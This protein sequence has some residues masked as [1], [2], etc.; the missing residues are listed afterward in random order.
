MRKFSF[1]RLHLILCGL[2]CAM[3]LT[4]CGFQ[5][6]GV[7]NL[8]FENLYI[9]GS[10]S[11]SKA[12]KKSLAVNG[13]KI[14]NDPEQAELMLELMSESNEKRILSLSG[15][16]VV[17]EFEL[18]YRVHFRMRDPASETW[19]EVQM[20]EGRRDFSYTDAELLAKSFEETRLNDDMR[21]DAV[22]EIMRRLVVQ[23][24]SKSKS[25]G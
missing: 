13:V 25:T 21:A 17:R 24:P 11:I 14:V 10:L 7:Q 12:L 23:K 2:I 18:Y 5:M 19:G 4:S 6:R 20:I 15:A 9:Q 22:R 1:T 8:A 3:A 16:G